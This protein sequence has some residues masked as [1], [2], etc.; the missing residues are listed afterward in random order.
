MTAKRK[1]ELVWPDKEK[2]AS[3]EPRI[4]LEKE[5]FGSKSD[6]VTDNLL[7]YGDNLLGLKALESNY[8]GK[9]KC[10][11]I[12]PPYN[13]KSLFTHYDDSFEHSQ[14]LNMMKERLVLLQRLLS[15]DGSI[16]INLDDSECHYAKIIMDELFGRNNFIDSII[17]EKA[18]T[19]KNS[20][21]F[22]S[23]SHDYILC[24]AKN[25]NLSA[26]NCW[27]EKIFLPIKI[28]IMMHEDL[29]N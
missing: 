17:W 27:K 6:G 5:R 4:L 18:H 26:E 21:K 2:W 9:V 12:D 29:G 19:R 14:W 10:I 11:Y 25:K 13:T 16:W 3:P 28:A 15:E 24:Y 23:S 22:F 20:S 8:S 1:L 7:I